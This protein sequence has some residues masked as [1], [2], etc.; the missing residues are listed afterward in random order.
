VLFVNI[1][2]NVICVRLVSNWNV[3]A[4][5]P[6]WLHPGDTRTV[7]DGVSSVLVDDFAVARL[8]LLTYKL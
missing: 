4:V 2:D 6:D 8:N 7:H 3:A 5:D 1:G